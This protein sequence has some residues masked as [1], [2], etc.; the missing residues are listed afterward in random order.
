VRTILANIKQFYMQHIRHF[1]LKT[2]ETRYSV[3]KG[4]LGQ[5]ENVDQHSNIMTAFGKAGVLWRVLASWGEQMK[6]EFWCYVH[7]LLVWV[8]VWQTD[9]L[10]TDVWPT[11]PSFH[12]QTFSR[13][14]IW[15]TRVF[16]SS[17]FSEIM[18]TGNGDSY[19]QINRDINQINDWCRYCFAVLMA[20]NI[21]K[22]KGSLICWSKGWLI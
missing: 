15:P 13:Q 12:R 6:E 21:V 5:V 18:L 4:I 14:D 9:I 1:Y 19:I 20:Q 11:G 10:P 17:L 16:I 8:D 22:T 3:Q 7:C 2:P